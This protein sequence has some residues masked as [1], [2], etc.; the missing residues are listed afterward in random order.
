MGVTN[1]AYL[2]TG[3][4]L[5]NRKQNLDAA[6]RAIG[7]TCGEILSVSSLYETAAWGKKDQ[8]PFLNQA[9]KI[10]TA[11]QPTELL[12]Q[13]LLIERQMGRQRK[14]KYGARI[15]DIDILFYNKVQ[16]ISAELRVPHPEIQNRRFA[17]IPLKEIAPRLIHPIF[18]KTIGTLL[19][20]CKDP[21]EVRRLD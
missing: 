3:G 6:R 7:E 14:E 13:I 15:I 8:P 9:L 11:L 10:R 18:K 20:E 5:G 12:Y 21:L 16:I 17:L 2:L 19:K 4:N 1:T